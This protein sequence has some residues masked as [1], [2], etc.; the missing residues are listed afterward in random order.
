ML[1]PSPAVARR[2]HCGRQQASGKPIKHPCLP[3][4]ATLEHKGH[5]FVGD[6]DWGHCKKLQPVYAQVAD[7]LAQRP[8]LGAAESF[9][10]VQARHIARPLFS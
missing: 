10:A 4:G 6:G 2:V 3:A 1:R 9:A 5:A 7:K 8:M